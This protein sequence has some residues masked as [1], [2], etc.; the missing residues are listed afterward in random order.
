MEFDR[1]DRIEQQ[2]IQAGKRRDIDYV[3]LAH[4]K[5]VRDNPDFDIE[6]P[7]SPALSSQKGLLQA[8]DT[9]SRFYNRYIVGLKTV[10]SADQCCITGG[11][12]DGVAASLRYFQK[13]DD[14]NIL[15]LVPTFRPLIDIAN[16]IFPR[17]KIFYLKHFN[18]P[19]AQTLQHIERS[20]KKNDIGCIV[21]TN[22]NNPAGIM[23]P[24]DFVAK[25]GRL[26]EE[27]KLWIIEDGAYFLHYDKKDQ[28]TIIDHCR[29]AIS[30]ISSL[31]LLLGKYKV[32]GAVLGDA[33]NVEP[34]SEH[35]QKVPPAH[36]AWFEALLRKVAVDHPG[37]LQSHLAHMFGIS[38][39]IKTIFLQNGFLPLYAA[40]R[41]CRI[42]TSI[43]PVVSFTRHNKKGELF[44]PEMIFNT[45]KKH[46]ILTTPL[47]E[48][49]RINSRG[50]T[51]TGT[52]L[53]KEKMGAVKTEMEKNGIPGCFP[54]PACRN[55]RARP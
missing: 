46:H 27:N 42:E 17:F 21:Y 18:E 20:C 9:I 22:P 35:T 34:F 36:Q 40:H 44:H 33:L 37:I 3:W 54:P 16:T 41:A 8:R 12:R 47:S 24:E 55:I 19:Y 30:L 4:G 53:L 15:F 31:K 45:M 7:G 25:L 50:I 38:E 13:E 43:G 5:Y 52:K 10:I 39:A 2:W 23:Y 32:G 26:G 51:E 6:I 14:R 29:C 49:I 1:I 11:C 28:T 48:G